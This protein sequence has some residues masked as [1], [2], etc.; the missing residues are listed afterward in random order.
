MFFVISRNKITFELNFNYN[1]IMLIKGNSY[2]R[3]LSFLAKKYSELVSSGADPET[4]LVILLNSF[5]KT[6]FIN[7]LK[8]IN[9]SILQKTAK[10][11]TFPGLCYN[12]FSDNWEYISNLINNTDPQIKPNLCGLEV[13]QFILKQ[14]IKEA[15]F[16]DYI[17][18]I[19]L[20]HQLFRRYSLIVQNDLTSE[21]IIKRSEKLR[22]S[23]YK[24]AQK[25]I[26]DYKL[27]TIKY[28]SFDYLRQMA[29]L[30]V[31]Y[32]NTDY[33][34]DIKYLIIDDMDEMP[35]AFGRFVNSIMPQ[36]K[37]YF[38]A[39]TPDG[40]AR[41]GYLCAY[42]SGIS[43]FKAAF[44]PEEIT[45]EDNCR[46]KEEAEIFYGNLKEG[47]KTKLKNIKLISTVKRMDMIDCA[48]NDIQTLI[49]AGVT[50]GDIAVITPSAD[51]VLIKTL[52]EKTYQIQYQILSG[53]E[54]LS[55]DNTIRSLLTI[56]K[57]INNLEAKDYEI[58]NLLIGLLKIPFK[59]GYEII[60]NYKTLKQ[61]TDCEFSSTLQNDKYIKF[62]T[63]LNSLKHSHNSL[64]EQIK[65]IY[66][67]LYKD[68]INENDLKKYDFL[69]KEAE[70]FENAFQNDFQDIIPQF[71]TQIENSVISEN[72][73][74]TVSINNSCVIVG[75]PQKTADLSYRSKY[76]LWLDFSSSEWMKEDKG[77]LYNAWG[78]NR[79]FNKDEFTQ[80]DNI[81]LTRDKTARIIKKIMYCA[82]KEIK[83]YAS[84]YDNSGN[85]NYAGPIDYI[86]TERE[87]QK[88]EFN[89][90]PRNDQKPVLNYKGGKMGIMAVPGAGKTT[91]LLALIIK[92]IR[93]GVKPENIFVLTYM[94][95]AA[96]NFKERIK[97]A[98]P[99]N[100]DISNISTI[101]GL[102]LR[103]IKENSNYTKAGLDS[104]FE[105]CDDNIKE[106]IIKELL[107]KSGTDED[108]FDNYLRCLSIV[109]LSDNNE[110]LKS[111]H[112]EIQ[113]FINFYNEYNK[114][115]KQNNLLD[116]DDMLFYAVKILKE[117][118]DILKH[119]QNICRYIIEDEAQDSSKIQQILLNLLSGKYNNIVRCGDI[120]Q[121]ITAT[122][123]NSDTEGFKNFLNKNKKVE[124]NSSQ[125][126]AKSVYS[127]ANK[128]IKASESNIDTNKAFYSIEM[129]GTDK[130][131]KTD[132]EPSFIVLDN[133]DEEKAFILN[134]IKKIKN[135]NPHA[136]VAILLRLNSQVN[137]Y[138][139]YFIRSGIKTNIRTD[140]LS[141]K[142]IYKIIISVL[143]IIQ[144]PMNNKNIIEFT[145]KY[146]E[147]N[148]SRISESDINFLKDLKQPF[149]SMNPD[150]LPSEGLCQIYWD[151]DYWLNESA[152]TAED[153]VLKAGLYYS[154]TSTDKSNTYMVSTLVKRLNNKS[155][156]LDELIKQLEYSASKPMSAYKFFEEESDKKTDGIDIMTMH[157]SK[158]D[159]F[160]YVFIAQ[161][162]EDNYPSLKENVKIKGGGHF[163][164]TVK[165]FA[166]NTPIKTPDI[167]KQELIYETLRLI[168]VGI[169]RAKTGL[170]ITTAQ[171]NKKNKT[172]KVSPLIRTIFPSNTSE[173]V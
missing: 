92:L 17:S 13:S 106:R 108:K 127:L 58:K 136:S 62:K 52:R 110:N 80:E 163:V 10:I 36:I 150:N 137:E 30:P 21:E 165:A 60:K 41:C 98:L 117:N 171:K 162:N 31:I 3:K 143:K 18:K 29:I 111:K 164:Q 15:D 159:E 170:Y 8:N 144:M 46:Y 49:K 104:D 51:E 14:S 95:S 154:K 27:K 9:P 84:L 118:P 156:N 132:T 169:T 76:Q 139:E 5:K 148:I 155:E 16:S 37:D 120:N 86:E 11:Y 53:S 67:N 45:I 68:N 7:E 115:L 59:K 65:I 124:M 126:C 161:M 141:Q 72:P 166:E 167:Q 122:F 151:V 116:Y 97:A 129:Q 100:Y 28:K 131:P 19:N 145:R 57:I 157:K 79:D 102:A 54:K 56:L 63:L 94:E 90:I 74:D 113:D 12:A 73:S 112:K 130:N 83:L 89:I 43:D 109:K 23:F 70:S 22:E 123:T 107:L 168:Y 147:Q 146:R 158:G 66:T 1:L 88:Q 85:E 121:A 152:S 99:D 20:L 119:Y 2:Q 40:S 125:R 4:I 48:A 44:K 69:L 6:C 134:E 135:N 26:D 25:A 128:L 39:Y 47:R 61:F 77:T 75:T 133:E 91:I 149:I 105:I 33:F 38:A 138:S 42:K 140:C 160:D 153:I 96:K 101:H 82:D 50:P 32:N 103:I 142:N 34:K 35:Y 87:T 71:I 24:E 114:T 93:E 173:N 64:T 172:I 55:S 78:F 81:A